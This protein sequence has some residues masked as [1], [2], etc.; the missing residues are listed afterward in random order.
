[1]P[2]GGKIEMGKGSTS[3][4]GF[5]IKLEDDSIAFCLAGGFL[6]GVTGLSAFGASMSLIMIVG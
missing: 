1:M 6:C 3:R 5:F 4:Q 2:K